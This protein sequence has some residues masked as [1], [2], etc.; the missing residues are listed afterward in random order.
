MVMLCCTS[1]ECNSCFT[2][3]KD[4]LWF[5]QQQALLTVLH[6][7]ES[8]RKCSRPS[9]SLDSVALRVSSNGSLSDRCEELCYLKPLTLCCAS[10]TA[11]QVASACGQYRSSARDTLLSVLNWLSPVW[12]DTFL[13]F[14]LVSYNLSCCLRTLIERGRRCVPG[15]VRKR[16]ETNHMWGGI[17]IQEVGGRKWWRIVSSHSGRNSL[18]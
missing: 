13:L 5:N 10:F 16:Q 2:T 14:G 3:L 6:K 12:P 7:V 11:F 15:D 1:A 17:G 9:D 4:T 18:R 8:V